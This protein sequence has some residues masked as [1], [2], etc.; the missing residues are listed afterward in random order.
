MTTTVFPTVSYADARAGVA[1]LEAIG[2]VP[3]AVYWSTTD[4]DLLDHA[5]FSWP[6]GGGLMC[7]SAAREPDH[8][9]ERRAGA[10]SVYCV[11]PTDAAV[12]EVYAQALAAG[13]IG[14][15]EP[16]D[17]DYGGRNGTVRDV[18]GNQWSFGSYAGHGAA[19]EA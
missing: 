3:V 2:F 15:V 16:Y 5:E 13:G 11:L 1:F 10:A 6:G 17:P 14:A 19:P 18:E 4:P 8:G 7:G 12:E 9:Y